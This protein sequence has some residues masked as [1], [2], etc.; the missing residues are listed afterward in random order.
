MWEEPSVVRLLRRLS[1]FSRL[2]IFDE[3]GIGLSDPVAPGQ[4]PSLDEK[5]ADI[6]AILD[7]V[8]APEAVLLGYVAGCAPAMV[9]AATHPERVKALILWLPYA[10]LRADVDYPIGV[11]D[12]SVQAVIDATLHGWGKGEALSVLAPSMLGDQRFRS[13][14]ASMERLAASPGTA[15]AL[16]GQWFDFDVR[17]VLP[18]IQAPTLV[19]TRRDQPLIQAVHARY[20][21]DHI[22]GARYLEVPGVDIHLFT[23]DSDAVLGAVEEFLG[24]DHPPIEPDRLLGTLLFTDIVGSTQKAAQLG[25]LR[26][27]DLLKSH[28]QLAKRQLDRFGGRLIETTGD[29]I[30]ALFEAPTQAILCAQAFR[31]GVRAL[32][33]QIRAGLH[34]GMVERRDTDGIEGIAIHIAA[35]IV[36]LAGA[37]EIL[38]SRTIKDLLTGSSIAM[39]SRGVHEL[40]GVPGSWEVY[41]VVS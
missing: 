10:R 24:A 22:K 36:A 35:R 9:F 37:G 23:G 25:D 27:S 6:Q 19:V 8:R 12:Q 16:V 11:S 17:S 7:E 18:S 30:L 28:M 21:A 14:W 26:W 20:V 3:R 31:D 33:L 2:V 5:V 34:S 4:V 29:G 15:A 39:E 1:A 41:A 40:K 38:V 13:W 32:D